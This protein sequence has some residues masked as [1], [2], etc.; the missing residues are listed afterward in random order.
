MPLTQFVFFHS[1]SGQSKIRRGVRSTL[2][3]LGLGGFVFWGGLNSAWF[4]L[5]CDSAWEPDYRIIIQIPQTF[6]FKVRKTS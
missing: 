4:S 2:P 5:Y 1:L 6:L 3:A